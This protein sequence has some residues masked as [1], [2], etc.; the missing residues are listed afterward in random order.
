MLLEKQESWKCRLPFT[1][2]FSS[3][4]KSYPRGSQVCDVSNIIGWNWVIQPRTHVV[5]SDFCPCKQRTNGIYAARYTFQCLWWDKSL[6]LSL[7]EKYTLTALYLCQR[8]DT[9]KQSAPCSVDS[10][11]LR[12][13]LVCH[14]HIFLLFYKNP[15]HVS[16]EKCVHS[17]RKHL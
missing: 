8:N 10:E 17:K 15:T 11:V 16:I 2:C 5:G 6:S 12:A 4:S 3:K 14:W 9:T 13:S 1:V 7:S